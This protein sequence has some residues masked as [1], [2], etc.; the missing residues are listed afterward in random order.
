MTE[1]TKCSERNACALSGSASGLF[2]PGH[3]A[4]EGHRGGET[5]A[6]TVK[7]QGKETDEE[8]KA[9]DLQPWEES[10]LEE[11]SRGDTEGHLEGHQGTLEQAGEPQGALAGLVLLTCPPH[12]VNTTV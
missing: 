10:L 9:W 3:K 6:H 5:L 12:Y 11:I 8:E 4:T 2:N 1:K 7:T